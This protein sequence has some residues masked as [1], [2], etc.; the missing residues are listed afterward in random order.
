MIELPAGLP[1]AGDKPQRYISL[2]RLS[3]G[4][5][6]LRA[7]RSRRRPPAHQGMNIGGLR[8]TRIPPLT[9]TPTLSLREREESSPR[10]DSRPVSRYGAD[11]T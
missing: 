10:L 6:R 9:L 4:A 5:C 3:A 7:N 11:M 1:M 2:S 8:R